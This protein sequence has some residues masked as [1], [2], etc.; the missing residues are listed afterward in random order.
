M[1][2]VKTDL[3]KKVLT[4]FPKSAE[5][6]GFT[7]DELFRSVSQSGLRGPLDVILFPTAQRY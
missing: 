1:S 7:Q 4:I 6:D 3:E 2:T 5:I